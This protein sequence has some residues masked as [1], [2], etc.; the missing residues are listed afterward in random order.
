MAMKARS[1][2]QEQKAT[3]DRLRSQGM[4]WVEVAEAFRKRY[5]VNA[6]VA[7][8]LVRG[9]SQREAADRWNDRWPASPKTFKNFSYWEL[10][11]SPT[12]YAPSLEILAR[13]AELYECS[14]A[15][16]V[17]D[18]ADH[19]GTDPAH[20]AKSVADELPLLVAHGTP[21]A[22]TEGEQALALA[23][24][25][26]SL[27]V[28]DIARGVAAWSVSGGIGPNARRVFLKVSAGLSLAA[29]LPV[30]ASNEDPLTPGNGSTRADE[31][32]SGIWHSR[33]RYPSSSRHS[34]FTSEHYVVLRQEG[35]HLVGQSLP[36]TTGSRLDLQLDLD[37]G[38]ASGSW[39]ER[40]SP[41]GYYRGAGYH[42]TLQL[43][44]NP[45]GRA[46][47]GK[48]LG[49][50]KD[51]TVNSGEWDLTWVDH[52]SSHRTIREYHMKL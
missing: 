27:D 25:L 15:D 12:G 13:L 33:Y 41:T 42:G 3:A 51:F 36:H 32:Y 43:L 52:A 38:V 40:T 8:R 39:S 17:A 29:S 5:R 19:R 30:N 1:A 31:D 16:L 11:P 2:R 44:I 22:D 48:W 34:E 26:E 4:S 50:G 14:V 35:T 46:M 9:W 28:H 6:R 45:M 20:R 37:K 10:W 47:K 23:K 18:C 24:R 7:F 49:F 21:D